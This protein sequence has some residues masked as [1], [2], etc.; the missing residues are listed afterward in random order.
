MRL[1]NEV[2]V[3]L[4]AAR[5]RDMA[6]AIHAGALADARLQSPGA[7]TED[8]LDLALLRLAM[9]LQ[10]AFGYDFERA[11]VVENVRRWLMAGKVTSACV[12]VTQPPPKLPD[13]C[14]K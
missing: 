10:M 5:C 3:R 12:P 13:G 2:T 4:N 7:S 8:L 1:P 6:I 9:T 11:Y 14:R